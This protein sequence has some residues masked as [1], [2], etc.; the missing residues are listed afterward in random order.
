M[1]GWRRVDCRCAGAATPGAEAMPWRLSC[2]ASVPCHLGAYVLATACPLPAVYLRSAHQLDRE[3]CCLVAATEGSTCFLLLPATF[4]VLPD[5]APL[6]RL[7]PAGQAHKL[8]PPLGL[9]AA[10]R[11]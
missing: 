11:T 7:L 9:P 5:V 2:H 8:L 3:I 4:W 1:L 6:V 10:V